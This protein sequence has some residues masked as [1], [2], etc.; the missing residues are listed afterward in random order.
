MF[1]VQHELQKAKKPKPLVVDTLLLPMIL[2]S[3][4]CLQLESFNLETLNAANSHCILPNA[5]MEAAK[6][7]PHHMIGT[8]DKLGLRPTHIVNAQAYRRATSV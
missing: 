5:V 4:P 2:R 6:H 7:E 3:N 8:P 1:I